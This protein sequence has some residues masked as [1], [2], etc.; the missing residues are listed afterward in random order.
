MQPSVCKYCLRIDIYRPSKERCRSLI[1]LASRYRG[2]GIIYSHSRERFRMSISSAS[3]ATS[4]P[5]PPR[6]LSPCFLRVRGNVPTRDKQFHPATFMFKILS[7]RNL[8]ISEDTK[9]YPCHLNRLP[10]ISGYHVR[11]RKS[12]LCDRDDIWSADSVDTH[13][14]R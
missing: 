14:R 2:R 13:I 1:L 8:K 5:R 7:P 11:I 4:P 12:W 6:R 3:G 10:R 9:D